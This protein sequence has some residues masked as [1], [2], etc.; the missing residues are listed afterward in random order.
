MYP[1]PKIR[2]TVQATIS[3][4]FAIFVA[5]EQKKPQKMRDKLRDYCGTY[6]VFPAMILYFLFYL[7]RKPAYEI[8]YQINSDGNNYLFWIL[9]VIVNLL[10]LPF[11]TK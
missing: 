5:T 6:F 3:N 11:A 9:I 4:F 2:V 8:K 7:S 1:S 10:I